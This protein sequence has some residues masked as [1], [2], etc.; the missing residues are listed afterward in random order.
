MLVLADVVGLVLAFVTVELLFVP[1]VQ[2][3]S[4]I[5][6]KDLL[7]SIISLP[8]WIVIAKLY[9]LYDQDEERTHHSTSDD[10][11]GVFHVVTIGTW[12]T[13]VALSLSGS[14]TRAPRKASASDFAILFITLSTIARTIC[15]R[16]VL[17]SE[18][19]DR[20]RGDI[21]QRVA[22]K[23]PRHPSMVQPCRLHRLQAERAPSPGPARPARTARVL[24]CTYDIERVV[25][26]RNDTDDEAGGVRALNDLEIRSTSCRGCSELMG[27]ALRSTR[28][29]A[30]RWSSCRRCT[31][32]ARQSPSSGRSTN[33]AAAGRW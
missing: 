5:R 22:R 19:A 9:R 13:F 30:C 1:A 33:G 4:A 14:P 26:A 2:H 15:R 3:A 17:T 31:S 24:V 25:V 8:L 29:R 23:L 11:V 21:G 20:R 28:S 16:N 18:H 7:L 6:M 27:R 10:I 32:R 12:L